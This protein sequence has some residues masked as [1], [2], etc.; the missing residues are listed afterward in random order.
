MRRE[1]LLPTQRHSAQTKIKTGV[2]ESEAGHQLIQPGGQLVVHL[3]TDW[4]GQVA[5]PVGHFR[6]PAGQHGG[7]LLGCGG[8]AGAGGATGTRMGGW[9]TLGA[10]GLPVDIPGREQARLAIIGWLVLGLGTQ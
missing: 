3:P 2:T 4:A 5:Q 8:T 10:E 9:P 6:G 1:K 7:E